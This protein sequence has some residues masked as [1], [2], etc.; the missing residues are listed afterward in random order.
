VPLRIG[1]PDGTVLRVLAHASPGAIPS[2]GWPS[3][4]R[5]WLTDPVA[6]A[7]TDADWSDQATRERWHRFAGWRPPAGPS[8]DAELSRLLGALLLAASGHAHAD[9]GFPPLSVHGWSAAMAAERD[10][11]KAWNDRNARAARQWSRTSGS[12]GTLDRVEAAL[13]GTDDGETF[14]ALV[15][16]ALVAGVPGRHATR[17][18]TLL[19]AAATTMPAMSA[20]T[21][22]LSTAVAGVRGVD[23][24]SRFSALRLDG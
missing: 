6:A 10:A 13:R 9:D 16:T 11:A 24:R 23:P 12:L 8:A 1:N 2:R 17:A 5:L 22:L 20:S 3:V 19:E 14:A 18:T 4:E 7:A 15:V 21:R